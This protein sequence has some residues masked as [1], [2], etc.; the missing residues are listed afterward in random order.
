MY[1]LYIGESCETLVE[2]AA[3]LAHDENAGRRFESRP[4][5]TRHRRQETGRWTQAAP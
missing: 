3:L 2:E 5:G 1:R 4:P